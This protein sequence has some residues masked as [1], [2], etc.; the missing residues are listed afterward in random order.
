MHYQVNGVELYVEQQGQ[1]DIALLFLHFYGGSTRTRGGIVGDLKE[2]YRCITY[3]HRGWGNSDKS[4]VSYT[5]KDLAADAEA[6]IREL[7]WKGYVVALSNIALLPLEGNIREMVLE[8]MQKSGHLSLLEA[9]VEI[10]EGI[11]NFLH[12]LG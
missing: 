8:D 1:G 9:P 6:L 5:I 4:A 11:S 2:N 3:D 12:K 10:S 7:K